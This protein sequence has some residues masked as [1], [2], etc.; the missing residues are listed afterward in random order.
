MPL[1]PTCVL[2]LLAQNGPEL[3]MPHCGMA[4]TAS[5]ES[6][7]SWL[8]RLPRLQPTRLMWYE[9]PEMP[10]AERGVPSALKPHSQRLAMW[11]PQASTALELLAVKRTL[12]C[13]S[14]VPAAR[15]MSP[16]VT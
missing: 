13:V 11:P 8:P 5:V 15:L 7:R 12:I 1:G 10:P 9:E 14:D 4:M 3:L 16:W 6:E 2:L